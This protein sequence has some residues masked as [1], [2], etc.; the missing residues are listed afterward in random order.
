MNPQV[1]FLLNKV[2]DALRNLNIDSAELYLKQA[3]KLDPKDPH[4]LRL[5]G[6]VAI[7]KGEHLQAIEY[8]NL[9]LRLLPKNPLT[10][11]NL[12]SALFELKQ[13]EAALQAYDESIKLEPRYDEAWLNKGNVL[14]ELRRFDEA[15]THYQYAAT[16]SPNYAEAWS[17]GGNAL[18]M[19][20]RYEDAINSYDYALKIN[21]NDCVSWNNKGFALNEVGRFDEALLHYDK[22]LSLKPEYHDAAFNK[23]LSLLL[24]G[25]FENGL[26][27][28][29]SRWAIDAV[30]KDVGKRYFTKPSW[31]GAESLKDKSIL[32][33]GEQ[34][35][36]DFIQFSR[37]AKLLSEMGAHVILEAPAVLVDL[38]ASLEGVSQL[39]IK[40]Q[41]LP[42]FDYQCPILS[43]PFTFKTNLSSIPSTQSYLAGNSEALV[44][45]RTRLGQKTKPRVGLVWSG[46][47]EHKN[48]HNR[49]LT[50]K[51]LMPYLPEHCDYFSLQKEVRETDALTLEKNPRIR[52]F[53]KHLQS[54]SDTAALIECLDLVISIDTG[55]AHLSG[56]LGKKTWVLLPYTP[57]WRWLLDRSDSPWYPSI[58][59]YRQKMIGDWGGVLEKLHFDLDSLKQSRSTKN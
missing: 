46:N 6:V 24:Q 39:V 48:D 42:D 11:S 37:Y 25:D 49:S 36:G 55:V 32:L 16:L 5:L 2:L 38:L 27:L 10:K 7:Q 8:L 47:P 26:P 34:G 1:S 51:D 31:T 54:F 56:A 3:N 20:N 29:E 17:N 33:Y 50:L 58:Y 14:F 59:L 28:Y 30:S 13:Y 35:L 9:S 43:L 41:T 52:S 22:A 18:R 53:A 4:A 12:G 15:L 21:P 23:S 19:L 57:D 40:D 45:W 44:E